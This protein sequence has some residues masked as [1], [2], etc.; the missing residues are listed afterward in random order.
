VETFREILAVD[1]VP[2]EG[3]GSYFGIDERA[4]VISRTYRIIS[5]GQPVM[6]ITEK[7]PPAFFRSLGI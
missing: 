6:V 5:S 4:P 3:C 1:Q 7:F 2:A